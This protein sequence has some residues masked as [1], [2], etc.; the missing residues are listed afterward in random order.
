MLSEPN[1]FYRFQDPSDLWNLAKKVE[2]VLTAEQFLSRGK[3][4]EQK[5][6]EALVASTF[7]IGFQKYLFPVEIRMVEVHKPLLDFELK[8][9]DGVVSEFEITTAYEPKYKI[10]EEYMDGKIPQIP[11][12]AFS[13]E[14]VRPEWI[15]PFIQS[16]TEKA[17]KLKDLPGEFNRQLLVYQNISGGGTDLERLKQLI[18]GSESIWQSIWLIVGVPDLVAMVLVSNAHGFSCTEGKWLFIGQEP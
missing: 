13:G 6:Q 7:S 2:S 9:R 1:N 15:A 4:S 12:R 10:R 8:S 14:P 3:D 17:K 16:K 11:I 18:P 5:L